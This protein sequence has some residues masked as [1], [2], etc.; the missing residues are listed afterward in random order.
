M[1]EAGVLWGRA[2]GR[3]LRV[4][5]FEAVD[6]AEMDVTL[7]LGGRENGHTRH[8]KGFL[9]GDHGVLRGG[10]LLCKGMM[11]MRR[12]R[13]FLMLDFEMAMV[14]VQTVLGGWVQLWM[15]ARVTENVNVPAAR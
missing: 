13:T 4:T 5:R 9:R 6:R 3:K 10:G 11:F 2:N 15:R 12:R 7:L 14:M 8:L 1:R